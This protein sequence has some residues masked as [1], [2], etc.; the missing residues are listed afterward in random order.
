MLMNYLRELHTRRR[1]GPWTISKER[2]IFNWVISALA[3]TKTQSQ[4]VILLLTSISRSSEYTG[5]EQGWARDAL[6]ELGL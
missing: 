1:V 2:Q 5:V 4:D 6:R 3:H